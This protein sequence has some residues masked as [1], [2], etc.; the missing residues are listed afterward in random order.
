MTVVS[1]GSLHIFFGI[2]Q[3][4]ISN[5][6]V[7]LN[8]RDEK[9]HSSSSISSQKMFLSFLLL[10]IQDARM[11][12]GCASASEHLWKGAVTLTH[13]G[14]YEGSLATQWSAVHGYAEFLHPLPPTNSLRAA[15][16]SFL[17]G[18]PLG[19]LT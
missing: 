14:H 10:H 11:A 4:L 5:I 2:F 12:P 16:S 19:V 7:S 17:A 18:L 8:H 13:Q 15:F 1:E 9:A 3:L 6:L